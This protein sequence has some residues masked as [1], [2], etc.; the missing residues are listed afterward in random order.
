[1]AICVHPTAIV[2][3][4]AVLGEGVRIDAFCVVG[5][6]AVIGD[7]C[8]LHSHVVVEGHVKMG[9]NNQIYSG[10]V[11]GADPQDHSYRGT[12]TVVEIGDDN[13]LREMVTI[14]RATEKE[15]GVTR[16]GNHCFLMAN[17]HLAHDVKIGNHVN[18]ANGVALSGHVHVQDFAT[19][20]GLIGVHHF[21]TIGSYSF[22]GGCSRITMDVP[23]Y[24]LVEGNPA[25]I[26]CLNVVGLKRQGF[27][28]AEIRSL[29]EAHRL[30]YRVRMNVEKAWEI[31]EGHENLTDPVRKLFAFISEQH[32]GRHGRARERL[33]AA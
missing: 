7:G 6:H 31:L 32:Q 20:S 10:T 15:D 9:K 2:D 33:R 5:P 13:I 11:I 27:S 28:A 23:P 25:D 21:T 4:K 30:L 12:P 18:M 29:N 26:R 3:P 24:M 14:H 22:V 17:V 19:L 16:L 8:Y 1:M